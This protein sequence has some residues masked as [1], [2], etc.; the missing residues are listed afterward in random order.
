LKEKLEILIVFA[1][2]SEAESLFEVFHNKNVTKITKDTFLLKNCNAEILISGIGIHSTTYYLTKK[3]GSKSY[4]LVIN[5]GICGSFNEDINIGD[6]VSVISDE[7]ADLGIV[8]SRG[9]FSTLFEEKILKLNQSPYDNGKIYNQ[10]K[11]NVDTELRKVTAITVNTVSGSDEQIAA[12]LQ[13]FNPDIETM[14][15]AAAAYVCK[16]EKI[17]FLQIRAVSNIVEARN[18]AEWDIPL[19]IN[20]LGD[21]LFRILNSVSGNFNQLK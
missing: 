8:N 1:T 19:A 17:D 20:N 11:L 10:L 21:E 15:G 16:C 5:A 18:K 7:F 2:K 9:N 4:D 14:E 3:L 6:C 12:R 13:K